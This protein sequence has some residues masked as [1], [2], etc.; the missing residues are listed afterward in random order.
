[1]KTLLPFLS[2]LCLT[3]C[4]VFLWTGVIEPVQ[5]EASRAEE[6][7]EEG[8]YA[9]AIIAYQ[10][11]IQRRLQSI[12]RPHDENPY[13]YYLLIG[14]LYLKLDDFSS[15]EQAYLEAKAQDVNKESLIDRFVQLAEFQAA[16]GNY[17]QAIS[18][19]QQYRDLHPLIFDGKIDEVHKALIAH[20]QVESPL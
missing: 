10:N 5:S 11:H 2:F 7:A 13:F 16:K 14:D 12:D 9:E 4:S 15:A 6:L 20:E 17:D 1:M 8:E 18:V 19:L 3:G